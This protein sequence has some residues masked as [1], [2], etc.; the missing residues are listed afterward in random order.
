MACWNVQQ[1]IEKDEGGKVR[2]GC[3]KEYRSEKEWKFT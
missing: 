3:I 2:I 1:V